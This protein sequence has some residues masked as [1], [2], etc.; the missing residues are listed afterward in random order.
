M[1]G[2]LDSS[3]K[4]FIH[5]GYLACFKMRSVVCNENIGIFIFTSIFWFGGSNGPLV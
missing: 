5:I 1:G 2:E 4:I 3:F